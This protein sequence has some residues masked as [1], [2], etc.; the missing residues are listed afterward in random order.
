MVEYLQKKYVLANI[1]G[2]LMRYSR[3]R[4]HPEKIIA[5]FQEVFKGVC[6]KKTSQRNFFLTLMAV[7][8]LENLPSQRD[9]FTAAD[10]C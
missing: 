6:V 7:S 10:R 3:K 8:G 4:A 9:C 2:I 5:G 1:G